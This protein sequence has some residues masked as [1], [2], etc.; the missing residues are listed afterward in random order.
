M[1]YKK[2]LADFNKNNGY[3]LNV[4][5]PVNLIEG[6]V[7]T[8]KDP[9]M[10]DDTIKEHIISHYLDQAK[11]YEI[12]RQRMIIRSNAKPSNKKLK[13]DVSKMADAQTFLE[14]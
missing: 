6:V 5:R 3:T 12:H 7:P 4:E 11:G 1:P 2:L 9:E 13:D 14:S 8:Y 10:I